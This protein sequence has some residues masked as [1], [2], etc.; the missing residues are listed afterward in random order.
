[1]DFLARLMTGLC[2]V[3]MDSSSTTLSR[4]FWSLG[5]SP[6]PTFTT[7]FSIMGIWW[8]FENPNCSFSA[9][10]TWSR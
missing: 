3:M 10:R 8:G 7:T 5:A 2:P 4:S 1:M 6:T 9:G